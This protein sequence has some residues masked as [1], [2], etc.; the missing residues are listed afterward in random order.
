M[1]E[2]KRGKNGKTP[3][4]PAHDDLVKRDFT[5]SAPNEL[6]LTDITEHHT[7]EGKVYLCAIKDVYSNQ[8]VGYSISDRM[9]ARLAVDALRSAVQRR[10]GDVAAAW[11]IPTADTNF[12]P[13]SS[14]VNSPTTTSSGPW[15]RSPQP[16]T[17]PRRDHHDHSGSTRRLRGFLTG[18]GDLIGV[19][20]G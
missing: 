11:C 15:D 20:A 17:T 1:F 7:A 10:G 3:G 13:G 16:V 6:W 5:S 2:K 14:C 19:T 9:E 12:D 8:I 4:P 18:R